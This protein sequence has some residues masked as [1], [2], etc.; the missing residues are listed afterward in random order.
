MICSAGSESSVV[1]RPRHW[2]SKIRLLSTLVDEN[3]PSFL[4]QLAR[5]ESRLLLLQLVSNE[6]D[7]ITSSIV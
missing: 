7:G 2:V 4:S 1:R 6:C 5:R 3:D